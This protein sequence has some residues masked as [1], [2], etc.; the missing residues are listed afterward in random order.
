[1]SINSVGWFGGVVSPGVPNH[2]FLV[3]R[4]GTE[5]RL[6][7]KVPCNILS[8]NLSVTNFLYKPTN[9]ILLTYLYN[10]CMASE[11]GFCINYSVFFWCGVDVPQADGM[12]VRSRQQV[13]IQVWIP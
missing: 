5:Q 1:V 13:A 7:K 10:C 11:N 6:M 3:I 9:K 4:D 8:T 12:I 2:Q